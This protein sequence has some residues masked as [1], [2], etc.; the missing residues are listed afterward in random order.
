MNILIKM[1]KKAFEWLTV[2]GWDCDS[3]MQQWQAD[4]AESPPKKG[5]T[6]H[7]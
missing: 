2:E 1:H 3:D 6:H 5:D 4:R 7:S